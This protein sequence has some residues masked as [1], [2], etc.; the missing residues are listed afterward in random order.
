MASYNGANTAHPNMHEAPGENYENLRISFDN[1]KGVCKF[2]KSFK[3][4]LASL[5]Y[6]QKP[7]RP[8]FC[9]HISALVS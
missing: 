9:L 7:A 3:K 8:V 2:N 6:R 1:V 5:C 4:A